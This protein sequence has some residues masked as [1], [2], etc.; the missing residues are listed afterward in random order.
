MA[1]KKELYRDLRAQL[2]EVVEQM[3]APDVDIEQALEHYKKGQE[4][5]KKLEIHLEQAKIEVEKIS[6]LA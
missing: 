1:T 2:D 3:Q 6:K 4:L 5:V